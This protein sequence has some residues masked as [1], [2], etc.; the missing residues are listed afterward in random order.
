MSAIKFVGQAPYINSDDTAT[1]I[2]KIDRETDAIYGAVLGNRGAEYELAE[3]DAAT[4]KAAGYPDTA[5]ASVASWAVAKGWTNQ[6]A[7][8]DIL[9]TAMAWRGAMTAIRAK[10]LAYKQLAQSADPTVRSKAGADWA[11]FVTVIKQQLGMPT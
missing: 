8:D 11:G 9:Q 3:A 1:L 2:A 10:R 4:Y 7:A 5:P 6:Q